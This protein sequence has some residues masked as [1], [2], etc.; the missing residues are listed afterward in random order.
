MLIG[1]VW[2][3]YQRAVNIAEEDLN[4]EYQKL[5]WF[6]RRFRFLFFA[7]QSWI[8]LRMIQ[9]HKILRY[10]GATQQTRMQ[11]AS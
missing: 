5:S 6:L 11:Q 2:T 10:Q 3:V 7:M 4:I 1:I 8:D 9:K